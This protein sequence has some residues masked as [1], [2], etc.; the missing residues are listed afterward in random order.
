MLIVFLH[1]TDTDIFYAKMFPTVCAFHEHWS[2]SDVRCLPQ[3]NRIILDTTHNL[4][5]CYREIKDT[6]SKSK[7]DIHDEMFIEMNGINST[8]DNK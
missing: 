6:N 8:K 1:V 2:M 5:I 7:N 3:T 4:Q